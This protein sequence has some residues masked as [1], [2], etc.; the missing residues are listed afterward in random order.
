MEHFGAYDVNREAIRQTLNDIVRAFV[1]SVYFPRHRRGDTVDQSNEA[2]YLENTKMIPKKIFDA[3]DL[4][5]PP[6]QA[7]LI[8]QCLQEALRIPSRRSSEA[9][10]LQ[11]YI[12]QEEYEI[13]PDP[14]QSLRTFIAMNRLYHDVIKVLGLLVEIHNTKAH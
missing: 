4:I 12:D 8:D 13:G 6:R 1:S 10:Y 7:L 5:D 2:V 9:Q 14:S 11:R 3:L